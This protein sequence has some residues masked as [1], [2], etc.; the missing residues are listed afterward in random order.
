MIKYTDILL[1]KGDIMGKKS[2]RLVI[3]VTPE[4]KQL[5]KILAIKKNV[6]LS[7]LVIGL[8]NNMIDEDGEQED[9]NLV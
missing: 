5:A 9:I 8:L 3:R 4:T 6:T 2:E 1:I 7:D